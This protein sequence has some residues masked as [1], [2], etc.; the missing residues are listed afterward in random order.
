MK[1]CHLLLLLSPLTFTRT[2]VGCPPVRLSS[3]QTNVSFGALISTSMTA[4]NG[5][6]VW[7][8]A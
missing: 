3:L 7:S 4:T 5:C 6:F 2:G 8:Q 1:Y